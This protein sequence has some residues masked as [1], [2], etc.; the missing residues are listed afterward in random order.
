MSL[1]FYDCLNTFASLCTCN[2]FITYRSI[3]LSMFL[4]MLRTMYKLFLLSYL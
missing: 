2:L 4:R 3:T 1:R